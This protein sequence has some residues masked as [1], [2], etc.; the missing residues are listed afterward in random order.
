MTRLHLPFAAALAC[1]LLAAGRLA[2]QQPDSAGVAGVL[3]GLT[4]RNVGPNRGGR[5]IAAAGSVARP[6]EYYF[7]ATGGGLWKTTDGGQSW[8]AVTDGKLG[9][10]SVGAVAVCEANPDVAYIGMGETELRGNIM[11][12]DGVYRS[13]DGGKSWQHVG[14]ENTQAVGKIVVSPRS[15]DDVWV[16]AFGHVYGRGPDRGV[17]HSTDGGKGW[18]KALYRDDHTGAIDLVMDAADPKVLYAALW[19]ANRT[20]WSLSSGGP[21]SGLFKSTDEGGHW[22]EL[23][24]N[25]GLPRGILG[26]IGVAVSPA[27][28]KRVFALVEAQDGGVFRS[29]DAG[30][31]WTRTNDERKLRQRAFYYTRIYADPKDRDVVYVVNVS[32]FRSKDGGKTFP[33]SIRPPHG[34]NHALW[35]AAN[36][37]KRMI[38]ANDGGANVS[39][40]GG[41]TWTGQAYPTAQL[42][43]IIADN[44]RP[45]F[46]CGA[47]QDN[48]TICVPGK[49]W[50][51][52]SAGGGGYAFA[53]GGGESGYIANSPTDPDVY[54]A[55]SYGGLLTAFNRTNGQQRAINPWPDNPMGYSASDIAERFQWTFPIVVDPLAP[56][57][58]YAGS[59]HLWRTTN[60]GQSWERISPDLTRHD[61]KTLGP[62]GGPITLDQTGVE[63]YGTVFTIAPSPVQAG[64]IW[65]GSDDGLVQLTRDAGK[66]WANVTPKELPPFARI[67]MVEASPQRAGSAYLAANRYQMDDEGVYLYRTDDFGRSWT[68]ITAGIKPNDYARVVREDP[69]RAGLLYAGTEH[70]FHVS[71]DDGARWQPFA[72]NLPDTQVPDAVIQGGDVLIA[73]HGRSAWILDGGAD[74]L[75]QMGP[76]VA[77]GDVFLYRPSVAVRSVDQGAAIYYQLKKPATRLVLDILDGSGKVVRSFTT[78]PPK[79][80]SA[81]RA[82]AE[83][84]EDDEDFGPR[85]QT[86]IRDSAGLNKF[87]WDM[88]YAAPTGFP[89][90]ILW[91]ARPMGPKAVPGTY[92]VRLTADGVVQ[93]QPLEIQMDPRLRGV[94]LADLQAQ[95]D[96]ASRIADRFG[97][98]NAAVVR[99]RGT[100]SA[101]EEREKKTDDATVHR[102][103]DALLGRLGPIENAI[104][105]TRLAASEDPLNFPIMLNNKIAALQGVVESSD[106]RPTDQSA[107]VLQELSGKLHVQLDALGQALGADLTAFN[108]ALQAKGLAPV[109]VPSGEATAA[110]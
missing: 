74:L 10:S 2:A 30:A 50:R 56:R 83:G 99:I 93:T 65:T 29:D 53:V 24:R 35:I 108:V 72:L 1:I 22:T 86:S 60:E 73:T 9:S 67:S 102:L 37:P 103:A 66:T 27:D 109:E 91:A 40:N 49:D 85:A 33:Q 100:R 106:S 64:I 8:K 57:T 55:G 97:Q 82:A 12:G 15:C 5:S 62:S 52:L 84:E 16:A 58:L 61:P 26:K 87:T 39:V 76:Q 34:D 71:F 20:P 51:F 45:Y 31:T 32:F 98:A 96:L 63:T 17:Y 38:E 46:A 104:Y 3:K 107:V 42:Y 11:Q 54:F 69:K 47:Q 14:L 4:W 6:L 21:G 68:R 79:P 19:D 25:P 89:K 77:Q 94:T 28:P 88:R 41:E 75:R 95:F 105:Q 81:H 13:G 101:I 43:H 92:Q 18:T 23:S 70:G 59:Q 48:S 80:D 110:R 44:H 36:D 7:G 90:M 78:A